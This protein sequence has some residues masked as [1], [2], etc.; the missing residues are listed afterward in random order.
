MLSASGM[1]DV[2]IRGGLHFDGLGAPGRPRDLRI[3]AG[4]VAEVSDRPILTRASD[5][6]IDAQGRW[7]LP[8]FIDI[9][10]HYDAEVE[11]DPALRE[12]LRHGVTTVFLGSC[13]LSTA[14]G[15]PVDLA[16][17]F[18]RVEAIPREA[19]ISILT[20]R[21]T[22]STHAEYA[23]HLDA[24]PLG[25]NVASFVGY[26]AIRAHVMGLERSLD[27]QAKPSPEELAG[28]EA[29]IIEGLDAGFLGLSLN[30]LYWD[31][32]GGSRFRSRCLPSTYASWREL[33]RMAGHV[34]RRNRNLQVIPNISTRYELLVYAAL[35]M[36]FG[37]RRTLR[38]S[39]VSIM[40]LRG[41]RT[42][43]RLLRLLGWFFNRLF[44]ARF[45]FQFLPVPFDIWAD[46][47]ENVV[48]EEFGAGAEGLDAQTHDAR[49]ELFADPGFRNRFRRQWSNVFS[50]R[51]FHR[52]FGW[53]TVVDCP[54]SAF[55]GRTFRD[56][57]AE[58]GAPESDV[59][60]DMVDEYGARLRWHTVVGNDRAEPRQAL[61]R[62]P[63]NLIG[64]SDAG[65]HLRNMAFYNFPLRM[66]REVND[67]AMCGRPFMTVE[68]AVRRLTSEI[69][70]WFELDAGTLCRGSR[71]DVVVV[72]PAQLDDRL[73]EVHEEPVS[74]LG[75][76]RRLVRRNPDAVTAV[77]VNG[78]VVVERG[79]VR[80]EVGRTVKAGRFLG[81][82]APR[83]PP[84]SGNR[85]EHRDAVPQ[86]GPARSGTLS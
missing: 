18:T 60:L 1:S 61:M 63:D 48:F 64:F 29:A 22:W 38:T 39:L 83:R 35:S 50:P 62:S 24:L 69:A 56:I 77:L 27:A 51:V 33:R 76:V 20:S 19:L 6:V 53:A 68:H 85:D 31:K 8:G 78:Q 84:P 26:S 32:M 81:V 28:M 54:D 14:V 42:L 73:D 12:S 86:A 2:V 25:P 23:A 79:R 82:E 44:G 80:P 58:R 21:K 46:G 67:A 13:S 43:W 7:V 55:I 17:M 9:H 41:N 16:D 74:A 3:S 5:R 71:A 30:T 15:D 59:F 72:D 47:F 70:R 36:G 45:R 34:R 65:A 11:V 40:D 52:N 49:A 57:A 4:R 10:T 75:G 66:L 37:F